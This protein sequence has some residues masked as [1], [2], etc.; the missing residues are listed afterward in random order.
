M[1]IYFISTVNYHEHT[2]K[3]FFL[4]SHQIPFRT[5]FFTSLKPS[6]TLNKK[7]LFLDSYPWDPWLKND[8]KYVLNYIFLV[9]KKLELAMTY[10][11]TAY[12]AG[13][14][15]KQSRMYIHVHV[16]ITVIFKEVYIYQ[17]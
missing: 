7:K 16:N 13:I 8:F 6:F 17:S 12:T 14:S 5:Y 9:R 1:K 4:I 15:P 2:T 3:Y 11:N 10:V